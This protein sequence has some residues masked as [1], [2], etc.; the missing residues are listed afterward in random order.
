VAVITFSAKGH[1]FEGVKERFSAYKGNCMITMDDFKTMEV[2]IVNKKVLYS[3]FYRNHGHASSIA[4]AAENVEKGSEYDRKAEL[5]H[6]W[7]SGMLFL[8][9]KRALDEN[10]A[11]TVNAFDNADLIRSVSKS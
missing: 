8:E 9:T 2:N 5:A 3:N 1:A 6:I 11:I 7:N 4:G 10:C